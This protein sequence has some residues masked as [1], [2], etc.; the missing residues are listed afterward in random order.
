MIYSG[1][2]SEFSDFRIRAKVPDPHPTHFILSIFG[3]CKKT[4]LKSIIK[5]NLST[6]CNFIFH[7]TVLQYSKSRIQREMT[8]LFICSFIFCWIRIRNNNSG[9]GSRQKFRIRIHNT[10]I[11]CKMCLPCDT[12]KKCICQWHNRTIKLLFGDVQMKV[13]M[14]HTVSPLRSILNY[15]HCW[16]MCD[17]SLNLSLI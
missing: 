7:T 10:G 11:K 5:K 9:S 13:R 14:V 1:S 8:F 15:S 4:T 6:I 16:F 2:S 17:P 3:N 12:S